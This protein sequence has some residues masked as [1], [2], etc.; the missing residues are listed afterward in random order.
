MNSSELNI[1]LINIVKHLQDESFI[2][3]IDWNSQVCSI[4]DLEIFSSIVL[5]TLSTGISI[6]EFLKVLESFKVT[7]C[8]SKSELVIIFPYEKPQ[9]VKR[10]RSGNPI[11]KRFDEI[12][13]KQVKLLHSILR[14]REK[15]KVAIRINDQ[16][17]SELRKSGEYQKFLLKGTSLLR[18]N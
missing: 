9:Q 12:E 10:S 17:K 15:L 11:F 5:P 6:E 3:F 16:I 8:L 1:T 7:Y 13:A 18:M 2:S 4:N 14:A